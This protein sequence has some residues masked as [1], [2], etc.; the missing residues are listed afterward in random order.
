MFIFYRLSIESLLK[1]LILDTVSWISI[2][3]KKFSLKFFPCFKIKLHRTDLIC[4]LCGGIG[5][6]SSQ[7]N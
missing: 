6:R 1:S 2:F 7:E 5:F 4:A 3:V